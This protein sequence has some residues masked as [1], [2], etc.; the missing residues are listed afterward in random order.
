MRPASPKVT[1]NTALAFVVGLILAAGVALLLEL[2]DRKVRDV[3]DVVAVL[4]VPMLGVL[5]VPHKG[6]AKALSAVQGRLLGLSPAA[7]RGAA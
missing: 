2:R 7:G 1:L 3:D 4:Q 6:G 5:P